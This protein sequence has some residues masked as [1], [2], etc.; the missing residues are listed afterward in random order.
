MLLKTRFARLVFAAAALSLPAAGFAQ[1]AP[2]PSKPIRLVVPWAPGGTSDVPWRIIAPRLS[3]ALGQPI[4]VENRPGA[5][6]TLGAAVVAAVPPDGYTL[7]GTSNVLA[8][9][10]NVY[11]KLQYDAVNDFVPIGQIAETCSVL[12]V[13]PSIPANSVREFVSYVKAN[14]GKVDYASTGNGSGQ[15]LFMALFASMTGLSMN[16]IPYKNV[17]QSI[18]ELVGGQV[19]ANMPGLSV[20]L[21]HIKEGRLRALGVT[22]AKRSRFLPEAPTIDES[23]AP[24]FDTT[25][26]EGML[27][28]KGLPPD[29]AARLERELR[30]VVESP[31]TQKAILATG[32]EPV[33]ATSAQFGAMM[34][35]ESAKWQKLVR[36]IGA[37]ID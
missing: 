31:D 13:H 8:L 19:K 5:G 30:K 17:G 6:S 35:N 16:H 11:R 37:Y 12:V 29:I 1:P 18:A 9:S 27:A 24:G 28:P 34:R 23:G 3:E 36:E 32:N 2:Y 14:P 25:L 33:F 20:V 7:L 22:C 15:H 26:R 10:A 21:P 4:V